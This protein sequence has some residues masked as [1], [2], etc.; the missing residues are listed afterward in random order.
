MGWSAKLVKR[1]ELSHLV[2]QTDDLPQLSPRVA[3]L[4]LGG[5]AFNVLLNLFG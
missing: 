4:L 3:A 2:G 5:K 1:R